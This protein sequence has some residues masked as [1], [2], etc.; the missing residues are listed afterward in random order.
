M[1][2]LKVSVVFSL[3]RSAFMLRPQIQSIRYL[4]SK[5]FRVAAIVEDFGKNFEVPLRECRLH[6]EDVNAH[7]HDERIVFIENDHK[8]IVEGTPI[9]YSVTSLISEYFGKFE[10]TKIAKGMISGSRW[11][12]E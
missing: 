5:K 6:L 3:I 10:S 4:S 12:R 7:P 11:P 8:Y 2:S 1:K 9:K